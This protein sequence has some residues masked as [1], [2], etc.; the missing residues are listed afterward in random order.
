MPEPE[1]SVPSFPYS[2]LAQAGINGE[3]GLDYCA[4]DEDFY[5]EMLRI[6]CTQSGEKRAEIVSLFECANWPDYAIKVHAL[7]STA[8]TIG[9]EALSAQA[10][11]LELAGKRG[12][13]DFI[14]AH[15]SALLN[16][17][18]K[19]CASIAGI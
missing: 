10:K 19:L 16:A 3:L 1:P 15:H 2:Q 17:Y 7:K 12:D 8:L 9:A 5:R 18:D 14:L 6:F 11:E 4:G 13:A